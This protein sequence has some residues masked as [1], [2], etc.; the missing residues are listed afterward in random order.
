MIG[1]LRGTLLHRSLSGEVIVEVGG[2]GH[3]VVVAPA[4]AG[5]LGTIGG[6]VFLWVHH[7]QRED[8]STL[9]GFQAIAEREAFEALLRAR[10]VGPS[11]ALGI[12]SVH[13]PDELARVIATRDLDALCLVPGI[14]KKTAARMLIEL[15]S[16]FD[17]PLS[18]DDARGEDRPTS[19]VGDVRAALAE[20]GYGPEEVREVLRDVPEA[21]DA[22][23]MLRGAL[24]RLAD[25]A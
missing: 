8:G 17:L 16:S 2:L 23:A 22:Q 24:L 11:L 15:E 7:H 1:S 25:S 3:R 6:E 9:Y 10:G 12:L 14:G 21:S 13:R 19:V 18:M 4:P 5:A 20:L